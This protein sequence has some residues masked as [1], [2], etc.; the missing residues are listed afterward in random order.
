METNDRETKKA[1]KR[2]ESATS[3]NS[4]KPKSKS[5][6]TSSTSGDWSD[7]SKLHKSS[8]SSEESLVRTTIRKEFK[9]PGM[10]GGKSATALTYSSLKFEIS[11]ARRQGYL[12]SEICLAII[13]KVADKE[14][15]EYFENE[16]DMELADVL[17]MLKCVCKPQKSSAAFT[18]FTNDKQGDTEETETFVARVLRLR[19]K[20]LSSAKE[21]GRTYIDTSYEAMLKERS[22]EVIFGGLRDES[23][24]SALRDK[25]R[26]DYSLTD[27]QI[28]RHT[29]DVVNAEQERKSKLFGVEAAA[30]AAAAKAM[31]DAESSAEVSEVSSSKEEKK[32]KK[33]L[34]PFAEIDEL[35][36]EMRKRDDHVDAKLEEIT[37]LL[38]KSSTP[39]V[40]GK[41][42]RKCPACH[43]ANKPRCRHC[44]EYGADYHRRGDDVCPENK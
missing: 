10:I 25:L 39:K 12:D 4:T 1:V 22:F 6:N 9:L 11:K 3:S 15:K 44:W 26:S 29:T 20:V 30:A 21:E 19:K 32:E 2:E 13:S 18:T 43:G 33:K 42:P 8:R 38:K 34:N 37:Q 28:L 27:L 40:V 41:H 23:I 14:L 35:R 31:K 7:S 16:P 17:E 5:S 36:S 24:R